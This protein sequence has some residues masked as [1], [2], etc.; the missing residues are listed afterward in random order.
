MRQGEQVREIATGRVGT[1]ID[2]YG[3]PPLDYDQSVRV[4]FPD[5]ERRWFRQ[6]LLPDAVAPVL[7]NAD[8][9]RGGPYR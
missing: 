7:E 1:V 6:P 3:G 2:I 9:R 8:P 5:G 4:E